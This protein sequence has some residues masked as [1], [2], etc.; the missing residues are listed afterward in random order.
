MKGAR[1][2]WG[3][4][5]TTSTS[6]VGGLRVCLGVRVL[7]FRARY[8]SQGA[9]GSFARLRAPAR[10]G[11]DRR[12]CALTGVALG[13]SVLGVNKSAPATVGAARGRGTEG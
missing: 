8:P 5:Q 10:G 1:E 6:G 7:K 12:G 2:T 4:P 11:L 3:A 13:R 9:Y